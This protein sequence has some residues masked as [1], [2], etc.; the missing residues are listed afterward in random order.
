M[1]DETHEPSAEQPSAELEEFQR[2]WTELINAA[3]HARSRSGHGHRGAEEL[4]L[5]QALLM[6]AVRGMDNPSVGAVAQIVGVSSPSATRMIQQLERKGMMARRR[7]ER[8]ERSTVVALTE[9]GERVLAIRRKE[10]ERKQ[11]QV[12]DAIRPSLRPVVLTLLRDLRAAVD[13]T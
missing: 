9:E 10:M 7:S 4:T 5:T 1:P 13:D 11:R 6:E 12:F 3:I 2:A 8:D